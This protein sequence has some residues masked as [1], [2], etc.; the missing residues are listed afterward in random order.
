MRVRTGGFETEYVTAGSGPWLVLAHCL[1]GSMDVWQPHQIDTF[2]KRFHVL[3]YDVRGHGQSGL[4]S[5][6]FTV[7]DLGDDLARLMDELSVERASVVGL[8][9]GGMLAQCLAIA[10][11]DRVEKLVLADTTSFYEGPA[12]QM[13]LERAET[14]EREGPEALLDG[15]MERWFTAP[16]RQAHPEVVNR[17]RALFK[18]NDRHA[19]AAAGRALSKFDVRPRLGDIKAPTLWLCGDQDAACPP[20]QARQLAASFHNARFELIESAA[21]IANLEQPEAFNQA[22]LNFL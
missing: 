17:I 10:H 8:S 7:G 9:M 6:D 4:P 14:A 3:A 18:A 22:V 21:H 19:Y 16:F 13:W 12:V 20:D 5:G 15:T 1:G 2:A 11:P